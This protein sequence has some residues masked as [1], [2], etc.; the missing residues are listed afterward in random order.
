MCNI[1]IFGI[2]W[3]L[4]CCT[5]CKDSFHALLWALKCKLIYVRLCWRNVV[6]IIS[7]KFT[8][9]IKLLGDVWESKKRV[10]LN[11][12]RCI[13]RCVFSWCLTHYRSNESEKKFIFLRN[14]IIR[15]FF[16][17]WNFPGLIFASAFYAHKLMNT[18]IKDVTLL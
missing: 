10:C 3:K 6:F 4:V 9:S 15:Y 14:F 1:L 7:D 11:G 5:N 13:G 18:L 12:N 2:F 8:R 17:A 16:G